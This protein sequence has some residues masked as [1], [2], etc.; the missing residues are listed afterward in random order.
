MIV[1]RHHRAQRKSQIYKKEPRELAIIKSQAHK[2]EMNKVNVNNSY[3]ERHIFRKIKMLDYSILLLALAG[4][5]SAVIYGDYLLIKGNE[6]N[7]L[8][9][10]MGFS[11]SIGVINSILLFIKYKHLLSYHKIIGLEPKR[12]TL[13]STGMWPGLIA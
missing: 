10:L 9:Q 12:E 8:D 1:A 4:T 7:F 6:P 11:V 13:W 3:V 5:Y 2:K